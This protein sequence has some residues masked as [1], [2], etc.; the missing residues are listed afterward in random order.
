M[1]KKDIFA[2]FEHI[3]V[4]VGQNQS[5]PKV[6]QEDKA[7]IEVTSKEIFI[8]KNGNYRIKWKDV[9][10][11]DINDD[12]VDNDEGFTIQATKHR[13]VASNPTD[14]KQWKALSKQFEKIWNKRL[15]KEKRREQKEKQMERS[16]VRQPRVY[17]SN[18][19]KRKNRY[20]SFLEKN[21]NANVWDSDDDETFNHQRPKRSKIE[22]LEQQVVNLQ[23]DAEEKEHEDETM[24]DEEPIET[25]TTVEEDH[26]LFMGDETAKDEDQEE[27]HDDPQPL[28]ED[29]DDEEQDSP[30]T[31]EQVRSA[32]KSKKTKRRLF[33]KKRRLF[34]DEDSDDDLFND[35]NKKILTTPHKAQRVVSPALSTAGPNRFAEDIDEDE[36]Q[37]DTQGKQK[38][39]QETEEDN[40]GLQNISKFFQPKGKLTKPSK[41][42]KSKKT[43]TPRSKTPTRKPLN[44]EESS[45]S[46][47]AKSS[48]ASDFFRFGGK[49]AVKMPATSQSVDSPSKGSDVSTVVPTPT[50]TQQTEGGNIADE[51]IIST[52]PRPIQKRTNFFSGRKSSTKK[53]MVEEDDPIVDSPVTPSNSNMLTPSKALFSSQK[54][55]S[56]H[57][58]STAS[59]AL[60]FADVH[61]PTK[62]SPVQEIIQ[63]RPG[64][65]SQR[66]NRLRKA[67]VT[68]VAPPSLPKWR[69]LR[70]LGNSC[71]MNASL[72]MLYSVPNFIEALQGSKDGRSLVAGVCELWRQLQISAPTAASPKFV[73]ASVDS[74]TDKFRGF[75]QR[76]AHEFL[77]H[78][79]DQMHE[80]LESPPV[81]EIVDPGSP[82]DPKKGE[83]KPATES[84]AGSE[85]QDDAFATDRFFRLNVEVCLEC[86]SC[87]Y[88]RYVMLISC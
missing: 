49:K 31:A 60:E 83:E 32:S 18:Y 34:E 65:L 8:G 61:S 50:S 55:R 80:E 84:S 1:T 52:P 77:G 27:P 3:S 25:T 26:D 74:K 48:R 78:L 20:T 75:H 70:N 57:S 24:V 82:F 56:M 14:P 64:I 33:Q 30:P 81:E 7:V 2:S 51:S 45:P 36:D 23:P 87:G 42:T 35:D 85:V 21:E 69:G 62:R 88:S 39:E 73:K 63:G 44:E 11:L 28:A 5:T 53:T 13:V 15:E 10:Q 46:K 43:V 79:I 9:T 58:K 76:D 68:P 17:K 40:A 29:D 22:E 19:S 41:T 86:K 66:R 4:S 71:Y 54:R 38:E 16:T 59:M 37:D 67:I 47:E 72:Q 6:L 12:V